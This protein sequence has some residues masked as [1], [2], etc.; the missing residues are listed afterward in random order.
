MVVLMAGEMTQQHGLETY[1][2]PDEDQPICL[3]K[4]FHFLI[5]RRVLTNAVRIEQQ[6]PCL[7]VL[8]VLLL[9]KFDFQKGSPDQ[10]KRIA[11]TAQYP[12]LNVDS[13]TAI[14]CKPLEQ[15]RVAPLAVSF[16]TDKDAFPARDFSLQ[17]H[18]P[19][20]G[21]APYSPLMY[22][23]QKFSKRRTPSISDRS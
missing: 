11:C 20:I 7:E 1:V 22:F 19:K 8:P 14:V 9:T 18:Y 4:F 15:C 12:R 23:P 21:T 13:S 17:G 6:E 16:A 10:G 2:L 3:G 5:T